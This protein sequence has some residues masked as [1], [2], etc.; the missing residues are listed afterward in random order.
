MGEQVP[1]TW[2]WMLGVSAVPAILQFSIMLFL[3]ESPR[4]LYMKYD[5]VHIAAGDL[6]RAEVAAGTENGRRAKECMEKGQLVPDE[7][8]VMV[9]LVSYFYS[10]SSRQSIDLYSSVPSPSL[11]FVE[12]SSLPRS[13]YLSSSLTSRQ[14]PEILPSLGKPLLSEVEDVKVSQ[15]RRSSHSLLPPIPSKKS[16]TKKGSLKE[17]YSKVSHEIPITHQSSYGQAVLNVLYSLH[18]RANYYSLTQ[19]GF[20]HA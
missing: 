18:D 4:W 3:P 17:K 14:T 2:L 6:L 7:I 12:T 15:Q 16:G 19:D 1:G 10:P 13:S 5:F 11:N 8:V 20:T 9:T